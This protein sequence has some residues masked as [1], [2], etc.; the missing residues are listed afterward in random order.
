MY[1]FISVLSS[2]INKT[3]EGKYGREDFCKDKFTFSTFS[4]EIL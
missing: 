4:D 1:G 2:I 3:K